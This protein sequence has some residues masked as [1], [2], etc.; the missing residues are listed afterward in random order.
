VLTKSSMQPE[1]AAFPMGKLDDLMADDLKPNDVVMIDEVAHKFLMKVPHGPH[2]FW[3]GHE[4][5]QCDFTTTELFKLMDERRY[6]RPGRDAPTCKSDLH[7]EEHQQRLEVAYNLFRKKP[8]R[9]A[10]AKWM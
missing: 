10:E 5:K 4:E 2:L 3:N 9:L 7:A 8:K 1:P 6:Y